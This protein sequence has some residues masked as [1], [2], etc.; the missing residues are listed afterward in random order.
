MFFFVYVKFAEFDYHSSVASYH[1]AK[2][3]G[4]YKF[5]ANL[6]DSASHIIARFAHIIVLR[7]LYLTTFAL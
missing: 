6:N 1:I 7:T 2:Q 3:P 4:K 5:F